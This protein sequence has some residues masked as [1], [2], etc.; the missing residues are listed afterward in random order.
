MERIDAFA[1]LVIKFAAIIL[2]APFRIADHVKSGGNLFEFFL[3]PLV[4]GI[5][6]RVILF[7]ELA[8]S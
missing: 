3:R 2:F 7:G 8:K 4:I 6:V 5:A 1:A